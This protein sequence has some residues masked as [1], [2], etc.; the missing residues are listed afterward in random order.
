MDMTTD[1]RPIPP[2]SRVLEFTRDSFYNST[3][4]D[5]KSGEEVYSI[6][7]AS[8][9]PVKGMRITLLAI[10]DGRREEVTR[11]VK[12]AF[13]KSDKIAFRGGEPMKVKD[14]M[15][16]KSFSDPRQLSKDMK[17]RR[18]TILVHHPLLTRTLISY[19]I[20]ILSFAMLTI[21]FICSALLAAA[22]PPPARD[23]V[24][25]I[26]LTRRQPELQNTSATAVLDWTS[27]QM[28]STIT[29]YET[30]FD[31]YSQNAGQPHPFAASDG[32]L[33]TAKRAVGTEVLQNDD[34]AIWI[35]GIT[36]GTPGQSFTVGFDTA[37]ADVRV[38]NAACTS[39]DC[40]CHRSYD[41]SA[42]ST[43]VNRNLKFRESGSE[44]IT[45]NV[46]AD[47]VT[48]PAT[49]TLTATQ[50]VGVLDSYPLSF[51]AY[52]TSVDGNLGM[53]FQSISA[54][55]KLSFPQSLVAQRVI[56]SPVFAFRLTTENGEVTL[57]G[58]DSAAYTGA[59]TYVP[60]T[61]K[62]F[63]QI[64]ID[65]IQAN[66]RTTVVSRVPAIIDT[67]SAL[68]MGDWA[69]VVRL[70]ATIPGSK[71]ISYG[72]YTVPCN[73]IP[74]IT[75]TIGGTVFPINPALFN[76]GPVSEGSDQ[77]VG[78]IVA[79]PRAT[80]SSGSP[81]QPYWSIGD[82]FLQN[83]YSVFDLGQNRVGFATLAQ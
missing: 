36:I 78:G 62:S 32:S 40:L 21:A 61:N 80:T 75:L 65:S 73:S 28:N 20:A 27:Q 58:T 35:G 60:V 38:V 54:Y 82:I 17:V 83:V 37:S 31:A 67:A 25:R 81:G 34:G 6:E 48:V 33:N 51:G 1:T 13:L 66:G 56:T 72:R 50:N 70:Y 15:K 52:T 68:I 4:I 9:M 10:D 77:C 59:I 26:A 29:K 5:H 71:M 12:G 24:Q 74:T 76:Q 19:I 79:I 7:S 55:N 63:W 18:P 8:G 43:S 42:S 47:L 64:N 39:S 44:A 45:G 22:S 53:A 69:N 11:V 3:L 46:Y 30:A 57:G 2:G 14:W 49:A 41:A 16:G 23:G